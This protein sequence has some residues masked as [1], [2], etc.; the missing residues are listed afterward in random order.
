MA[1]VAV[2]LVLLPGLLVVRAPWP[3]VA[4]LSLAFWTL[5]AWWPPLA[6][7]GRGRTLLASLAAMLLLLLLRVLPKHEVAPP[8]GWRPPEAAPPGPPPPGAPLPALAT[9][10]SLVVLAAALAL[11]LPLP[12]WHHAPGPGLAFQTTTARVVLWR[13][14]VPASYEPLLPLEPVGAHAPALATLAADVARLSGADPGRAQL[15]VLVAAAGLLLVGLFAFHATWL[16]APAAALGAL[17]AL[18]LAPWPGFLAAWGTGEAILA[19]GFALPAVALLLGRRSRSSAAAAAL[20]LAAGLAA[21]ALLTAAVTGLATLAALRERSP[22]RGSRARLLTALGLALLL[23]APALWPLA[24][25]LSP[26]EALAAATTLRGGELASFAVGLLLAAL[27]PRAFVQAAERR[28]RAMRAAA[29]SVAV[30]STLL[31][32]A[33]VH[34]W[35][36]AGQLDAATRAALAQASSRAGPLDAVCAAD[37]VR[38]F[39]PALAGR[40]PGE[41]GVLVPAPYAEEWAARERRPCR[42]HV[43]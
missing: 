26:R 39:V 19:L 28:S 41:P 7:L 38:D 29:A 21:H 1:A 6:G 15:W 33:R 12:L 10:P 17:G 5:S 22:G 3:V 11:L 35:I 23:A 32:V 40:R 14:A 8:P 34:G 16:P 30:L 9:S 37:G 43:P 24:R 31:L 20:L 42:Y 13:D 2:L 27:A 18:A 4:P 25:A 36:A